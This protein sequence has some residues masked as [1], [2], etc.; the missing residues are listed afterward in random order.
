MHFELLTLSGVK[1]SGEVSEVALKT[2]YGSLAILPH[3]EP[4][5]AV[6]VPGPVTV[7]SH[8]KDEDLFAT[9]GG[10]IEVID[11]KVRLLA[12]EADHADDLIESEIEEALSKAELAKVAAKEGKELN[13]AQQMVDRHAVRLEVARIRRRHRGKT[14]HT[15]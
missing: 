9:F 11:N 3:H 5:T 12:D 8:G 15:R 2:A 6:V 1:Y 7:R 13:H 14:N 4:F 10:I